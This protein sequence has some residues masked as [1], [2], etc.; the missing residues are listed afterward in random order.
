M[1]V[2]LV[3]FLVLLRW[4]FVDSWGY[5]EFVGLA[6]G[7]VIGVVIFDFRKEFFLEFWKSE[8][9]GLRV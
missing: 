6:E 8:F 4:M 1:G 2:R 9:G 5:F 3:L 7:I